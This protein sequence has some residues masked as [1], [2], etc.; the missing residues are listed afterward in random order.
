VEG[1][2]DYGFDLA[3]AGLRADE[4]EVVRA[5]E[6]LAA[7]LETALPSAC[8]V[9]RRRRSFL[10]RE[11][12]VTSIELELGDVSFRLR[13]SRRGI[14]AERRQH[15]HDMSRRTEQLDLADWLQSLENALRKRAASSS[16]AR[17]AL[18]DLLDS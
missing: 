9:S 4:P 18:E 8:R 13:V 7:K 15:V 2:L 12:R 17:A 1:P 6:V 5:I 11:L 16:D 3:A 14:A 10:S